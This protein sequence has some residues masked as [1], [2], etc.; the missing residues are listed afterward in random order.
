MPAI[1]NTSM[2]INNKLS[3]NGVAPMMPPVS[4]S[5]RGEPA[6]SVRNA[7]SAMNTRELIPAKRMPR[8][9]RAASRA[10]PSDASAA[11]VPAAS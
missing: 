11:S 10:W 2:M 6:G 5:R 9:T 7:I 3:M 8:D 4:G 1:R